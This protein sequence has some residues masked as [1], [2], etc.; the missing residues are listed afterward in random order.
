MTEINPNIQYNLNQRHPNFKA[1]QM[2]S[3]VYPQGIAE[4]PIQE[5]QN[6]EIALPDI[7][8]DINNTKKPKTFKETVKKVDM[9]QMVYP[10]LEH[11]VLMAGTTAATIYGIE[12][13]TSD[14][15]GEYD[16]S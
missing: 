11:P 14:W 12:K 3:F 10:W 2:S 4:A 9:F 8:N 1:E 5:N 16:K 15:Q 6:Q 7:Y 13:L